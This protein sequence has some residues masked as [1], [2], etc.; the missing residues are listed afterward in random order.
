[1]SGL[2]KAGEAAAK[3]VARTA[4]KEARA[5]TAAEAPSIEPAKTSTTETMM[6]WRGWVARRLKPLMGEER[7]QAMRKL[8]FYRPDEIHDMHGMPNPSTKVPLSDKDPSL[9]RQMR[10]PSPGSE[11]PVRVPK[12]DPGTPG[13][14]PYN[15]TYYSRDTSRRHLDR[16]YPSNDIQRIKLEL[17]DPNDAD[18]QEMKEHWENP[19]SSPGNQGRFAT[20]PSDF[21]PSGLRASMS[22]NHEAVEQSLDDNMP[23][24]LPYPDWYDK[25]DEVIQWYKERDLPVPMGATGY[26]TVPTHLRVARW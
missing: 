26:G 21:D 10:Y 3:N 13:D 15:V 22:T 18:V 6:P 20:G 4:L 2:K 14:D 17:M 9:Y 25:Q 11:P 5:V 12:A 7:Y 19:Q 16:A 1:M 8:V 23:D 24:H